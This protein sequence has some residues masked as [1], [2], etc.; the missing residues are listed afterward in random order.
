MEYDNLIE[1]LFDNYNRKYLYIKLNEVFYNNDIDKNN[2]L[3]SCL[4]ILP[5]SSCFDFLI[6]R[7]KYFVEYKHKDW[8]YLVNRLTDMGKYTLNLFL[9]SYTDFT[10][11]DLRMINLIEVVL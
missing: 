4:N 5:T 8:L 7:Y 10:L 6:Y 2:F 9:V 3:I 1:S 11:S